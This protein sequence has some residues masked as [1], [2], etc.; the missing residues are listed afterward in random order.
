M[1]T[2]IFAPP[3]TGKTCLMTYIA[4]EKAFDRERNKLMTREIINKQNNGF[5]NI[6]TIPIHCV[7]ANYD[8]I[9]RK[10]RYRPR[11]NRKINPFRLGFANTYVK[12]HFNLP[13]EVICITEAQKYLNSR[14]S[15]YFP[16]WQSRWYEQHG[17]DDIDIF[18]DTQRP[19]LIDVNIRELAQFIEVRDLSVEYDCYGRVSKMKWIIRRIE[20]SGLFDRYMASGKRDMSCYTEEEIVADYNVFLC[21]DSQSCKPKFYE[22]H[23]DEDFDYNESEPTEDSLEGYIKFLRDHDDEYP[24]NFY[25]K[26][27]KEAC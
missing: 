7:S 13:Y 5:K 14:M 15:M 6:K 9:F 20:N 25:Q 10:F 8:M 21:Y 1:I 18:L 4:C 12:T 16:D 24:E 11:F 26:R 27:R 19:M 17:H 22:G 2:I 23:L 3:R